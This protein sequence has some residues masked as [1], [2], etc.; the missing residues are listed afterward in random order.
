MAESN[1]S[2]VFPYKTIQA[3]VNDRFRKIGGEAAAFRFLQK[4][5][6]TVE[7][8]RRADAAARERDEAHD[9]ALDGKDTK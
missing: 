3:A 6:K 7:W 2:V 4:G 1:G 9:A 5:F 8:R